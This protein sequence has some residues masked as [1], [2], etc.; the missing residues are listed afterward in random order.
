[1]FRNLLGKDSSRTGDSM[2][3]PMDSEDIKLVVCVESGCGTQFELTAG[4]IQFYIT[5]EL[6]LPKRCKP[7][8][9]ERSQQQ[10][11]Q[12]TKPNIRQEYSPHEIVC[13]NCNKSATVP[14]PPAPGKPVYC[15]ICWEGIKNLPLS[16]QRP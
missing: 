2:N 6:D 3:D 7:C 12:N 10:S 5:R 9:V 13:E 16:A 11:P 4:E 15:K 8:R 1:M 14:F